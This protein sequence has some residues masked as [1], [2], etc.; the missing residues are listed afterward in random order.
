MDKFHGPMNYIIMPF[1]PFDYCI[2]RWQRSISHITP[3][4]LQVN[5]THVD[6]ADGACL[7]WLKF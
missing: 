3:D 5:K 2:A 4:T 1:M 6:M 7:L